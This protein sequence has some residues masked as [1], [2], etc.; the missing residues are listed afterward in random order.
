MSCVQR[1][2]S[3]VLPH[4]TIADIIH[5]HKE[6]NPHLHEDEKTQKISNIL[7][8]KICFCRLGYLYYNYDTIRNNAR[9]EALYV[10]KYKESDPEGI[11]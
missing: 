7:F 6:K 4:L 3:T 8:V 11:T 10:L 9:Y 5:K 2:L 1:T